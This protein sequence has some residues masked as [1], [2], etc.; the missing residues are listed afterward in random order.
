MGNKMTNIQNEV[1]KLAHR[2]AIELSAKSVNYDIQRAQWTYYLKDQ[3]IIIY[4][5]KD[6]TDIVKNRN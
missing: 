5:K 4:T 1:Y 3:Q 2:L 6:L